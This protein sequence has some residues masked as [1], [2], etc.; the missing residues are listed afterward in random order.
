MITVKYL[1]EFC[2]SFVQW[3]GFLSE[4]LLHFFANGDDVFLTIHDWPDKT[5]HF[6]KV[7]VRN[8]WLVEKFLCQPV[9]KAGIF[10]I[11]CNDS[12]FVLRPCNGFMTLWY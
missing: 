10:D 8:L 3:I 6:V 7:N 2:Q 11:Q 4:L 5:S 9:E 1:K 12:F